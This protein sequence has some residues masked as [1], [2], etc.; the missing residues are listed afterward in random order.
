M[1]TVLEAVSKIRDTSSAHDR[2]SVI[3][4]MGRHCGDIA[5]LGRNRGAEC[6]LLPEKEEDINRVC[7]A[8]SSRAATEEKLHSIIIKAEGTPTPG[9]ASKDHR[10]ENRKRNQAD[11]A[12]YLQRG[13][14]PTMNDRLLA[15]LCAEKAVTLLR[16]DSKARL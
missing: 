8:R 6:V 7:A 16:E 4:V 13:G 2:T 5:L 9:D 1:S 12:L 15:T 14:S 3:E 11:S 10:R